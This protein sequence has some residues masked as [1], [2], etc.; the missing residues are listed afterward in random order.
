VEVDEGFG[1]VLHRQALGV[2]D[3]ADSLLGAGPI[4]SI[5][6]VREWTAFGLM[7]VGALI[8]AAGATRATRAYI[9]YFRSKDAQPGDK[10]TR[11]IAGGEFAY[12]SAIA[13]VI[14]GGGLAVLVLGMVL[15]G[16]VQAEW[17]LAPIVLVAVSASAALQWRRVLARFRGPGQT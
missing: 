11:A 13:G 3:P 8:A 4:D 10:R 15:L 5:P 9:V 16:Y 12:S 2:A 1:G 14:T 7:S 6:L 17:L